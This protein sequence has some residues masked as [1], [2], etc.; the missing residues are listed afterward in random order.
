MALRSSSSFKKH[1]L[2][3]TNNWEPR[4]NNNK[5][6]ECFSLMIKFVQIN[7]NVFEFKWIFKFLEKL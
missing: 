2:C 3:E 1:P 7:I 5:K 6:H 4:L